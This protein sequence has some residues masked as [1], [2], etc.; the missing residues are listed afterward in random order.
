MIQLAMSRSIQKPV[1]TMH[2]QS[3]RVHH[4]Y[5]SPKMEELSR[6]SRCS[7]ML[8]CLEVW[9]TA[10]TTKN[11][12]KPIKHKANKPNL[13]SHC[14]SNCS[15][16]FGQVLCLVPQRTKSPLATAQ[17]ELYF[18]IVAGACTW[19]GAWGYDAGLRSGFPLIVATESEEP[20]FKFLKNGSNS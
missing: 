11:V 18:R 20:G 1:T 4:P 19:G 13:V 15:E 14:C 9:L 12:F 3:G 8:G 17:V 2:E 6:D 7:K 10:A 16:I 5:C